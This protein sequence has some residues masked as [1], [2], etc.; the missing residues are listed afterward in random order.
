M[1]LPF[2][3]AAF[4]L[5]LGVLVVV[6]EYG[7]YLAAR[8]CKVK[9]LRFSIGFGKPL[10]TKRFTPDGTEWSI[11]AFPL[12]GYVKMLDE[13]EGDVA[14]HELDRAFNRQPV[15]RRMFIVAAGPLAN[16]LLAV[17]LYWALFVHGVAGLK[18]ML[19][20]APPATAAAAAGF[21]RGDLITAIGGQPVATWQDARLALLERAG[22]AE[23]VE[24]ET[25]NEHEEIAFRRLDLSALGPDDLDNDFLTKLGLTRFQPEL[26][27]V[28]GK[29]LP[30]GAA[31]RAGMRAGDEVVSVNG[32]PV[33]RWDELVQWVR[34]SPEQVLR[35]EIRR[36][37][38]TSVIEL[39]PA[40][41]AEGGATVGKVGAA[42]VVDEAQFEKLLTEVRYPPVRALV[43]ALRKT[44]DTSVLS[45]KMI[46]KMVVGQ[47][48]LKNISGPITIADYAGQSAHMGWVPY[49][50]FLALISISLGVLNLLPIP[51]L[52]GG[53]LMYHIAEIIKGGPVSEKAMEIGQKVGIA[54]LFILMVFALFNDLNRLFSQ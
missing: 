21:Q 4:A 29:I 26:P 35:L 13:H 28:V 40:A 24:V 3:L 54:L 25:R 49:L 34:R 36:A 17:V 52:D 2:T 39:T 5:A 22:Q 38:G 1:S 32:R 51:L 10:A 53:H 14:P 15:S 45:L 20:E 31:E 33:K 27:P 7:H 9:V 44:W 8:L 41:V 12:G 37:A 19:G 46:G 6:H 42:P 30:Q 47:I 43:E 18:P 23:A 50:N 11:A 48:S 16:F